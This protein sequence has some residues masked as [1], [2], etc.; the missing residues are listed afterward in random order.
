[1]L[2]KS[3]VQE[4]G[5]PARVL[6]CLKWGWNVME[7]SRGAKNLKTGPNLNKDFFRDCQGDMSAFRLHD[8]S[9]QVF[10]LS[11]LCSLSK[12][13]VTVSSCQPIMSQSHLRDY[14]VSVT[15]EAK[16]ARTKK[17][18]SQSEGVLRF[19]R[20]APLEQIRLWGNTRHSQRESPPHCSSDSLLSSISGAARVTFFS[21]VF[22]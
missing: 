16:N 17:I 9:R 12:E 14:K 1:M 18:L 20:G 10:C 6:E 8:K 15:A 2:P 3:S 21:S 22:L 7:T 19:R 13:C 4:L 11:V 5:Q